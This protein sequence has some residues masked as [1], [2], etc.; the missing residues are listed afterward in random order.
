MRVATMGDL[1]TQ[2]KQPPSA[3][4]GDKLLPRQLVRALGSATLDPEWS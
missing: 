2:A 1:T 3:C 4:V